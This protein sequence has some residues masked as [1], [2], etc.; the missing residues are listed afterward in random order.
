MWLWEIYVSTLSLSV[1]IYKIRCSCSFCK[2]VIQQFVLSIDC[3]PGIILDA[4]DTAFTGR[5]ENKL[6][7][8]IRERKI[9]A[10]QSSKLR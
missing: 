4:R 3:V 1:L 2:P 6:I 10:L 8:I 5:Q 9:N 7:I